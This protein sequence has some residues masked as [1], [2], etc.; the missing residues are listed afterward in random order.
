MQNN[1]LKGKLSL[2]G[3][4]PQI[5]FN[6]SGTGILVT[7]HCTEITLVTIKTCY[8]EANRISVLDRI[9]INHWFLVLPLL[10]LFS[11]YYL[12]GDK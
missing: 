6:H 9:L 3:T 12:Q 1:N 4:L 11:N 5:L 10:N 8:I 7:L 2:K